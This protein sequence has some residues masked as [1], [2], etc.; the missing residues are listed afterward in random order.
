MTLPAF[1]WWIVLPLAG[2][3]LVYLGGRL[4]RRWGEGRVAQVL[5][6]LSL[7]AAWFPFILAIRELQSGGPGVLTVGAIALSADG[8]S[9]L[10]GGVALA[11][12]TLVALYS[13]ATAAE[14]ARPSSTPC[15][16]R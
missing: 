5:A 16:W 13:G 11:L 9:L 3:P 12:G 4:G 1:T 8:L 2:A 10:L 6:L 7:G 14:W 15:W